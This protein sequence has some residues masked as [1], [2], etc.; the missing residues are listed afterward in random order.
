MSS[1]NSND[2]GEPERQHS[3]SAS[4]HERDD[5]FIDRMKA[6]ADLAGGQNA[7]AR[8]AGIS[9]SGIS[10]YL[11]GGEPAR[12]ILLA[13]SRAAGVRIEWLMTGQEPM[14]PGEMAE[15][16]APAPESRPPAPAPALDHALFG[17][18]NE[19]LTRLYQEENAR[20]GPRGWGALLAEKYEEIVSSTD[21]PEERKAMINLIITQQ[22]KA[23]RT[24]PTQANPDKRRA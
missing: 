8:L 15:T 4:E 2:E 19:A 18:L 9:Q 17:L 20:V 13:L 22:R 5:A 11:K 16:R 10:R 24:P 3:S 12:P 6:M 23:I 14:R 1:H 21:D 7:L